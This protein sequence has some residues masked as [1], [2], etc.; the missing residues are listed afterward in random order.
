MG[1]GTVRDPSGRSSVSVQS[2][3]P[4]TPCASGTPT[5]SSTTSKS[6]TSTRPTPPFLWVRPRLVGGRTNI[7]G[8]ACLRLSDIDF[9]AASHDGAGV[10]WPIG[11]A[12]IAPYYDLVEDYVGIN[13]LTE[14][15]AELPDGR[16]QPAMPFT[17]A[18]TALRT[19]FKAEV[20][21]HAHAGSLGESDQAAPRPAAVPLLRPL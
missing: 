13:G 14:G 5:G 4:R 20:R 1:C 9:K 3:R 16:F 19:R 7:W 8:R 12:D 15:L 2:S 11:Y 18:E 21:S 10:D 17:C 6:P